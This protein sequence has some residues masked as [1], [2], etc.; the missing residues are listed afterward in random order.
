M[1]AIAGFTC[2]LIVCCLHLCTFAD[3]ASGLMQ[4]SCPTAAS[5]ARQVEANPADQATQNIGTM[6]LSAA[7]AAQSPQI[8]VAAASS[9]TPKAAAT[10][11]AVY[12]VIQNISGVQTV[13]GTF[14]TAAQAAAYQAKRIA[15]AQYRLTQGL[16]PATYTV[17]QVN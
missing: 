14:S 6:P 1:K 2:A 15:Q 7:A 3:G 11:Q 12:Q 16:P 10:A 4:G 13:V 8:T 5:G 17:K 9:D